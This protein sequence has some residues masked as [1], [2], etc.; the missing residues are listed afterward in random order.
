V[1]ER[2]LQ[3][4]LRRAEEN[5]RAK[6]RAA[7]TRARQ[8]T[9]EEALASR[10]AETVALAKGR[11][12]EVLESKGRVRVA[13]R[14]G[15]LWLIERGGFEG[16]EIERRAAQDFRQLWLAAGSE[17]RLRSC[18]DG[19]VRGAPSEGAAEAQTR[20]RIRLDRARAAVTDAMGA[21]AAG[22]FWEL[23][24]RVCGEGRTLWELSS[25]NR[26]QAGVMEGCLLSGL[27]VLASYWR[28]G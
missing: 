24:E 21:R 10:I 19:R 23:L 15:L 20:A 5:R 11:G 7:E 17:G 25:A 14:D 1:S 6:L 18:L 4:S 26:Q 28:I 8:K 12:E 3:R 13:S 27:G 9:E 2:S 16:A 22:R